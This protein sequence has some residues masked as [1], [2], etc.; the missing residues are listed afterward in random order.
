[1]R[2]LFRLKLVSKRQV[3]IP[4]RLMDL[5][6]LQIGDE[7][8]IKTS[9]GKIVQAYPVNITP[10]LEMSEDAQERFT[11]IEKE[12]AESGAPDTDLSDL[13]D[14]FP[15]TREVFPRLSPAQVYWAR[16]YPGMSAS[17]RIAPRNFCAPTSG[18][19]NW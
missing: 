3:T 9:G 6:G 2:D 1:M 19:L 18:L 14:Q 10:N 4:Q 17:S 12:R 11:Q 7:I 8:H 16:S 13:M 15:D 5:I